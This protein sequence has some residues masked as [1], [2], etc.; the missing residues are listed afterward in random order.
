M[1]K[2][3]F[4]IAVLTL[5]HH[6]HAA[7]GGAENCRV[8][9]TSGL[10]VP[11]EKLMWK[12]PCLDGYADGDGVLL[13]TVKGKQIGSFEGRMAQGMMA[14]GYEKRADGSQYDGQYKGGLRHGKGTWVSNIGNRYDGQWEADKR[15]GKGVASYA[16]GGTV[17]GEWLNDAPIATSKVVFA[18]GR[19]GTA[20]EILAKEEKKATGVESFSIRSEEFS[21]NR[22][23]DK[24]ATGSAAPF[25]K[26]YAE[27]TPQQQ[28]F[29]RNDY[30]LLHPGDVPPY[31]EK[32]REQI[33]RW[34]SAMHGMVGEEGEF[35]SMVDVDASGKVTAITVFESPDEKI[36]DLVK[37]IMFRQIFSPAR[38]NGNPC[39]MRYPFDVKFTAA[40][41]SG[42]H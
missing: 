18:G 15:A 27:M 17:D 37:R 8:M 30:P 35:L 6:A 25:N 14:E 36:T 7:T 21:F 23:G 42:Y 20:A 24:V 13:R 31:P 28:Q 12:G 22:F 11:A 2:R 26:G 41:G 5:A 34:L 16:T 9:T 32:G 39:A 33:F 19:V 4:L 29:I 40:T 1:K 10:D 38:C 3:I